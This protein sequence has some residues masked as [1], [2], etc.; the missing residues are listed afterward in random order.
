MKRFENRRIHGWHQEH[1]QRTLLVRYEDLVR[2]PEVVLH[3]VCAFLGLRQAASA[4][5]L[6]RTAFTQ[7]HGEGSC[8]LCRSPESDRRP[9]LILWLIAGQDSSCWLRSSSGFDLSR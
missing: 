2:Q 4:S 6:V 1:A 5:D 9:R 8:D 7:E 3:D